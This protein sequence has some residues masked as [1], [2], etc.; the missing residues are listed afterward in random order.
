MPGMR[1]H[2]YHAN[3]CVVDGIRFA[4]KFEYVIQR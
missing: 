2:K 1:T 4:S 3:P